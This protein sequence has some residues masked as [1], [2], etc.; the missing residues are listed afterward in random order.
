MTKKD[1]MSKLIDLNS[2]N[3]VMMIDNRRVELLIIKYNCDDYSV[4]L[5]Y[6]DKLRKSIDKL[7]R[8][9]LFDFIH[10][11]FNYEDEIKYVELVRSYE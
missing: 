2:Q 10:K 8:L 9:E 3:M 7:T 11:N 5:F 6:N 4:D 1:L